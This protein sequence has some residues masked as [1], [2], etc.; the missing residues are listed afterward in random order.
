MNLLATNG[1]TR[2]PIDYRVYEGK[3]AQITKNDY[4]QLMLTKAK[5][6]GLE[7]HYVMADSWFGGLENMKHIVKLGWKFIMGIK[8]N[9]LVSEVQ[10]TYRA[11]SQLDWT[12][13]QVRSVWLKG[14]GQVLVARLVYKNG[15]TRYIATNDLTLTEYEKLSI[16]AKKRWS[17][18]EFHRGIKKAT[19]IEKRYSIVKQSQLNHIFASFVT[20][21][22]MKFERIKT[23]VSWYE[24]KARRIR[25]GLERGLA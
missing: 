23:G 8:E 12:E 21:V 4:A 6:R 16:Q 5:D 20:F 24:Q 13:K 18:E 22:R 19:G 10:G 14:F 11:V 17:I 9:R 15:D 1:L 2:I 25:M 7:P 3:T